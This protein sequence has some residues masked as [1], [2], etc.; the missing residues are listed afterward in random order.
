MLKYCTKLIPIFSS[1]H[2]P[3]NQLNLALTLKGRLEGDRVGG[4]GQDG[5]QHGQG[6]RGVRRAHPHRG[7]SSLSG[8]VGPSHTHNELLTLHYKGSHLPGKAFPHLV[9]FPSLCKKVSQDER[10]VD[11]IADFTFQFSLLMFCCS[12]DCSCTNLFSPRVCAQPVLL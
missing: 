2:L 5:G 1:K 3:N 6:Q 9:K 12:I 11:E 8:E 10:R 4:G 7:D